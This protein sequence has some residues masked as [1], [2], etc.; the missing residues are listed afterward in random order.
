MQK[1]QDAKSPAT[2]EQHSEAHQQ[3]SPGLEETLTRSTSKTRPIS[4]AL[5]DVGGG[6]N[7]SPAKRSAASRKLCFFKEKGKVAVAPITLHAQAGPSTRGGGGESFLPSARDIDLGVLAELPL[8]MQRELKQAY[9]IKSLRDGKPKRLANSGAKFSAASASKFSFSRAAEA[10]EEEEEKEGEEELQSPAVPAP[11][12][13]EQEKE[14]QAVFLDLK[15]SLD[16]A[17]YAYEMKEALV[18]RGWTKTNLVERYAVETVGENVERA[19][20]LLR[21]LGLLRRDGKQEEREQWGEALEAKIR[22]EAKRL[23]GGTL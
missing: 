4:T 10:A 14:D 6:G 16:S 21:A 22:A 1:R 12:P 18:A 5:G 8:E 15:R 9:G 3:R 23:Y 2:S 20:R 7:R 19:A 11:P 17:R 13:P